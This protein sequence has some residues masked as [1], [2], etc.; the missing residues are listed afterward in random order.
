LTPFVY[1]SISVCLLI[2]LFS[3][4][5]VH[6]LTAPSFYTAAPV[7]SIFSLYYGFQFFGKINGTQLIYK[8]KTFLTSML[9]MMDI[10]VG[11]TISIPFIIKFGV[12]GAAWAML[13]GSL[14]TGSVSFLI[15]QH[16]Y[17]IQWE[18]K[19]IISI[20]SVFCFST[21]LTL[22]LINGSSA[23]PVRF[24]F[25]LFCIIVYVWLGVKLRILTKQ[26]LIMLWDIITSRKRSPTTEVDLVGERV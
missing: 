15:S 25:K 1:F 13:L 7:I 8:K 18:S 21:L 26:N 9:T 3:E 17:C 14:V 6:I 4:E 23:Y 10:G 16:Y 5:A 12:I 22:F 2:S 19:K 24:I 20:F 11:V